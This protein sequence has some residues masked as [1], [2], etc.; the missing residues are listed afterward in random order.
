MPNVLPPFVRDDERHKL[1]VSFMGS[2]QAS[3]NVDYQWVVEYAEALWEYR[4]KA[5]SAL[6]E[7][8]ENILKYLG[9]GTGLFAVGVLAKIDKNNAHIAICTI[10]SLIAAVFALFF[11][12]RVKRPDS[13]PSIP[14]VDEAMSYADNLK[15]EREATAAFLGQWHLACTD[16]KIT[17]DQKAWFVEMATYLFALAIVLLLIPVV[18]GIGWPPAVAAK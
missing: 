11:A 6:E 14:T 8:G 4:V 7:K 15:S 18:A 2:A 13:V 5:F 12:L 3:P 10:P 9:G 16:M 17:C 1:A